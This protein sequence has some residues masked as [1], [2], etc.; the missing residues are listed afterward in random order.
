[1]HNIQITALEEF[2]ERLLITFGNSWKIDKI[3]SKFIVNFTLFI[4]SKVITLKIFSNGTVFKLNIQSNVVKYNDY[5]Y[6]IISHINP[7]F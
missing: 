2:L 4:F 7:Y 1:M 3:S 5:A 6:K